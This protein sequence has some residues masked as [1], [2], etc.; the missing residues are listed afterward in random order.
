M[1]ISVTAL[2]AA[3]F[4]IMFAALRIHVSIL[5]GK[6]DVSILHDNKMDLALRIRRHGNFNENVPY[7]IVL[8]LIAEALGTPAL[9]IHVMGLALVVSRVFHVISL[10]VENTAS[11]LR[12]IGGII[13][14]AAMI[15][16]V[17]FI[18][19]YAL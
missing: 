4:A 2:Y 3:F 9:W 1:T 18:V 13:A 11:P 7:A 14:T 5:R 15:L 16:N 6:Y 19:A 10:D 8:M 17:G 12:I